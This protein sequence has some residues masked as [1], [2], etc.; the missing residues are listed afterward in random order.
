MSATENENIGRKY[1][2]LY[3]LHSSDPTWIDQ[4]KALVTDDCTFTDAATGTTVHGPQEVGQYYQGWAQAFGNGRVDVTNAAATDD[5]FLVEFVGRGTH[6]G[7]LATPTGS[8]PP[9]GKNV[10]IHFCS[11]GR[12]RDGKIADSRLYFDALGM[13]SQLGVIPAPATANVQATQP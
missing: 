8:L 6:D 5:Q 2:E 11:V 12:L 10:E 7:P 9:T 3:N 1:T 13:L 4:A